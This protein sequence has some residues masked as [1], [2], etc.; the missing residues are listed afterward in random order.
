MNEI[1]F[2][3][4][5]LVLIVSIIVG[6]EYFIPWVKES[7]NL[8]KHQILMEIVNAAVQYAEQTVLGAGSGAKRKEIVTQFLK[9]QLKAKNI[10]IS[11]EQLNA[12]I[13][14]AVY[15]MNTVKTR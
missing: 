9:N 10:S 15:T 5:K 13:E 4:L 11:D 3:L 14:S 7:T 6:M 8:A 12:L 1:L 2:E